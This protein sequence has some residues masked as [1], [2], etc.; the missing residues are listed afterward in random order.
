MVFALGEVK[1]LVA[2]FTRL[3]L[4]LLF[5]G[6]LLENIKKQKHRSYVSRS[7][8]CSVSAQLNQK[9]CLTACLASCS[10]PFLRSINKDRQTHYPSLEKKSTA[11]QA[12][13][14]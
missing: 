8:D 1:A 10:L 14:L 2:A 7:S 6:T 9:E 4:F 3:L 12:V 13:R 11:V 5:P